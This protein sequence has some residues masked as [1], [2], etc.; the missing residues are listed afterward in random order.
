MASENLVKHFGVEEDRLSEVIKSD[1][2]HYNDAVLCIFAD[3][4]VK[5]G[6]DPEKIYNESYHPDGVFSKAHVEEINESA[7]ILDVQFPEI[8]KTRHFEALREMIVDINFHS[9]NI[10]AFDYLEDEDDD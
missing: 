5:L 10:P 3:Y 2:F 6:E 9:L 4:C 7:R 1:W 8:Y